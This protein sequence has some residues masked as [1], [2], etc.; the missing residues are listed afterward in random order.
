MAM[1]PK[2]KTAQVTW[3]IEGVEMGVATI[4]YSLCPPHSLSYFCSL[5]GRQWGKVRCEGTS[6]LLENRLCENHAPQPGW[7]VNRF[8]GTVCNGMV[9]SHLVSALSAANALENLP[10]A[11][12]RR[13]ATLLVKHFYLELGKHNG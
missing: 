1:L 7:D 10:P 8:P 5:C 6:W 2:N 11:V 9:Y 13:E 3:T 4:R 12:L